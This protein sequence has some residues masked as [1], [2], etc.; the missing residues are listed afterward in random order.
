MSCHLELK[1]IT[2]RAASA[3]EQRWVRREVGD[4]RFCQILAVGRVSQP[5]G[6]ELKQHLSQ[7]NRNQ[8]RWR[9]GGLRRLSGAALARQNKGAHNC[10]AVADRHHQKIDCGID[11]GIQQ[12]G[13][14]VGAGSLACE[15]VLYA[16]AQLVAAMGVE[17][18]REGA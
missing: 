8:L 16:A 18:L 13:A 12:R 3:K 14:V 5:K 2:L 4:A 9:V 17:D 1:S 11:C 7:G 6:K 10:L 15:S